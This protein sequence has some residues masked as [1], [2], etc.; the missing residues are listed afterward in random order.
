MNEQNDTLLLEDESGRIA[1]GGVLATH[2]QSLVTGVCVALKGRES[3]LGTFQVLER[4]YNSSHD[5][6]RFNRLCDDYA[7]V[8][9][10]LDIS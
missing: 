6:Y 3:T 8:G 2:V 5:S 7:S 10:G 4:H 9:V 1:L